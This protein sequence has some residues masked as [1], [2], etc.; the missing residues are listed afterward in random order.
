MAY[1]QAD[2]NG[3]K[4]VTG[5]NWRLVHNGITVMELAEQEG[6]GSTGGS[7]EIF[8]GATKAELEAEVARLGLVIPE[9]LQNK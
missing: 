1:V 3:I 7:T 2:Q 9:H 5:K 6:E 8:V 4:T